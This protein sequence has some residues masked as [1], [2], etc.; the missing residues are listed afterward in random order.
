[1]RYTKKELKKRH[2]THKK[3]YLKKNKRYTKN[4]RI[5][6]KNKVKRGGKQAIWGI[7]YSVKDNKERK[8]K[9]RLLM[10]FTNY[11]KAKN[12]FDNQLDY[13]TPYHTDI[14]NKISE[15]GEPRKFYL[16]DLLNDDV[17]E[18]KDIILD[19]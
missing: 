1:M 4:K 14:V 6:F 19:E 16:K 17:Y 12:F 9:K 13:N 11:E 15:D 7:E 10:S 3:K 18:E 8:N 5:S 2:Q